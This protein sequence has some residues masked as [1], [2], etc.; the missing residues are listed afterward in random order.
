M[1][2]R[3]APSPTDAPPPEIPPDEKIANKLERS[4]RRYCEFIEGSEGA[5]DRSIRIQTV[6]D[7]L[8]E[9]GPLADAEIAFAKLQDHLKA[10]EELRQKPIERLPDD[11]AISG[12]T[13]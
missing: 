10:R 13:D 3:F 6:L 12:D 4:F 1:P 9:R 7:D 11:V 8:K 2:I 5:I